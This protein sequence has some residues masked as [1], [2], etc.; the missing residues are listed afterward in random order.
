[1]LGGRPLDLTF[2]YEA[3]LAELVL[4][5]GTIEAEELADLERYLLERWDL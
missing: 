2:S 3:D 5:A 1:M 4:V